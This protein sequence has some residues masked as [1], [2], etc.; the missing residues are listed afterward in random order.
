[1][2]GWMDRYCMCTLPELGAVRWERLFVPLSSGAEIANV[3]FCLNQ[4]AESSIKTRREIDP[5]FYPQ[6]ESLYE[7]RQKE[8]GW[9]L[10]GKEGRSI[11]PNEF[12]GDSQRRSGANFRTLPPSF[13]FFPNFQE[14]EFANEYELFRLLHAVSSR[15]TTSFSPAI[16][17][18]SLSITCPWS[19]LRVQ[20]FPG[21]FPSAAWS[22]QG[23]NLQ[24]LP[25]D[26]GKK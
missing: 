2:D 3:V 19:N 8:T 1:M 12:R 5:L 11:S 18:Y 17:N 23:L 13:S 16:D 24:F 26:S 25:F 7:N 15:S 9:M 4:L 21:D 20:D 14:N 22:K 6:L 10:L